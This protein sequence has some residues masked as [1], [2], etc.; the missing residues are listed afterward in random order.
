MACAAG[1]HFPGRVTVYGDV[2]SQT[3]GQAIRQAVFT[4]HSSESCTL[5]TLQPSLTK[6][7]AACKHLAAAS[8]LSLLTPY[9]SGRPEIQIVHALVLTP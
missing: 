1:G 2:K 3:A 7:T 4:G 8:L 6:V 9:K 5:V